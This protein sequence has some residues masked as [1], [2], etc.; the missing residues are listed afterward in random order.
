MSALW[1]SEAHLSSDGRYRTW[2]ERR[3]LGATGA[4]VFIM[5]N[6]STA[7]AFVDDPT[8]RR[9]MGFTAREGL[10]RMVVVNLFTARTPKPRVLATLDD[11][12]GP[13]ADDALSEAMAV[14]SRDEDRVICAWGACPWVK[15]RMRDLWLRQSFRVGEIAES[16]DRKLYALDL[17]ARGEPRHPLYVRGDAPLRLV[18]PGGPHA[19]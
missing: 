6:P 4:A 7:D 1:H 18:R 8:I 16:L 9:C 13:E 17:T 19:A 11:P 5:L 14:A 2:L 15:G 3:Q 10:A 12:V